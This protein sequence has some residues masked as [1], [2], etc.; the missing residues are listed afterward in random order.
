M[1][2]KRPS[3]DVTMGACF[4]CGDI[5]KFYENS[6][7]KNDFVTYHM[8][9]SG[10]FTVWNPDNKNGRDQAL[11]AGVPATLVDGSKLDISDNL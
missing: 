2:F 5:R 7:A 6:K 11:L 9:C 8:E 1:E 3:N 4:K 10:R